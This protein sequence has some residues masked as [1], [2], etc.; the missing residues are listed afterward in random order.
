M[1][2]VGPM[3]PA[4][5]PRI[6]NMPAKQE[7]PSRHSGATGGTIHHHGPIPPRTGSLPSHTNLQLKYKMSN[8]QSLKAPSS[9]GHSSS[10]ANKLLMETKPPSG[11]S[12][13]FPNLT[14]LANQSGPSPKKK[15][16]LEEKAAATEDIA[17]NR[18]LILDGKK[19]EMS[20]IKENYIET[21]SELFFLQ[22]G[23]NMMDFF[24]WKKRPTPQ[25]V[26]FLK[27]SNVDSDDEED[28]GLEI[29]IND[30]VHF[31]VEWSVIYY[32]DNFLL[33]FRLAE[34]CFFKT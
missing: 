27:S 6:V 8:Q 3:I 14:A 11:L 7:L 21:L 18:K 28:H 24:M 9:Q 32:R 22:N 16:K 2:Q 23:G 4:T 15:I 33:L 17:K 12:S 31:L 30:E 34:F 25:L 26:N 10:A 1:G 20:E 29:K 5:V 19:R 13:T